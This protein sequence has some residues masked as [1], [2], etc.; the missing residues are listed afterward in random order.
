MSAKCVAKLTSNAVFEAHLKQ[1]LL[2]R[3]NVIDQCTRR[4]A[5]WTASPVLTLYMA[6]SSHF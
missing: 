1:N 5:K 3:E 6:E 4:I 2:H